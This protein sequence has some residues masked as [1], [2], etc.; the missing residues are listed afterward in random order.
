[1]GFAAQ[2]QQRPGA[3][4]GHAIRREWLRYY[5]TVPTLDL[6]MVSWDTASTWTDSD[7]SVG[8]V[9]AE[10]QRRLPAR[11]R[12]RPLRGAGAAPADHGDDPTA[13]AD[14]TLIEETE[15]GRALVQEMRLHEPVRPILGG[16]AD[17]E[18]RLLARH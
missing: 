11:R 18:A 10:G 6:K 2:Y 3:A 8:T 1:M 12:P 13:A 15:L 4:G 7:C 5:D 9:W 16:A 17:K 14:A